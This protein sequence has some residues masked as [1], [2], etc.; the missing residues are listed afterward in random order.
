MAA[1]ASEPDGAL[2]S[3]LRERRDVKLAV[4]FGSHARGAARPDSDVDV[5]VLGPLDDLVALSSELEAACGRPVDVV[6][7]EDAG[8]PLLQ[9]IVRDARPL[10]EAERGAFAA[11]RARAWTTLETDRPWF[12]RMRDAR[13]RRLAR[14]DF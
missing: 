11:W 6:R 1:D 13:L 9:A 2:A 14:G 8:F 5:A 4:L 10:H 7:L 12:R 3:V